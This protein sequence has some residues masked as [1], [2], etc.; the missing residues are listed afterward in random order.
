MPL[1]LFDRKVKDVHIVS[2]LLAEVEL[3]VIVLVID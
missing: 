3:S 1:K 2:V